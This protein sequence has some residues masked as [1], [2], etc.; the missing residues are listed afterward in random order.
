M[1]K[2]INKA[3][4]IGSGIMG[5]GIAALCAGAGIP[6]L[7][8]DIVPFDLKDEEKN[9]RDARNKIVNAGF[10]A[11]KKSSPP[12]FLDK[13]RDWKL[14]ETGNLENDF[15]KLKECD[16]IF[17]VIVE[18][19]KLKQQLFS[20]IE[21]IR[22]EDA[23]V[24]SNTSGLPL[25][26]MSAGLG[27]EFRQH[28]MIMHFFNPVRY[29]KLVELVKST[30]TKKD[31]YDF[32][33]N[34]AEKILGKGVVW[35]K[36]TPNFVGNRIGVALIAQTFRLFETENI[37]VHDVDT[38]FG[39]FGFPKTGIFALCDL[40]G[41]DT[42]G[43]LVKNSHDLLIK[44]EFKDIYKFPAFAM[45]MIGSKMF[46]NKT[47]DTGGFYKTVFDPATKKKIKTMLDIKTLKH[48]EF[49]INSAPAFFAEVKK[50][51]SLAARQR[52]IIES[53]PFVANVMAFLFVYAFGRVPE[54]SDTLKGIDD[55]M[56]WGYAWET[57]PFE[58]WD[59]Y[60]LKKSF[61]LIKDAGFKVPE[62]I[63]K[64]TE[65]GHKSF[66]IVKE[67]KKFYYDFKSGKYKE[68]V[69]SKDNII[70]SDLKAVRKNI[71]M[72][73]DSASLID[74]GDGVFNL[75]YHSKMNAINKQMIDFIRGAAAY[76]GDNGIG[77]VI[78][79]Q[80]SGNPGT[81]SAG[82]DLYYMITLAK[83][84][85]YSEIDDFLKDSH[86]TIISLKYSSFPVVAAPY[87]IAVGGGCE[88]CLAADRIVAHSE[89]YMGLVEI[90]AG[91]LPGGA[92]MIHLWERY[93]D[94]IPPETTIAD[95]GAYFAAAFTTVV[96]AKISSSAAEA[97]DMMYLRPA[98]RIVYNRDHLIGEA[99][100]E[101][102]RI[103][104]DGYRIPAKKKVY[105]MGQ[106]AQGMVLSRLRD[107]LLGGY[108]ASYG[109]YR[110]KSRVL[111]VGRRDNG[112]LC[113]RGLSA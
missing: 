108:C 26:A 63:K 6:T 32:V 43:H 22:S 73:S 77:L 89:L 106:A 104:E 10:D 55:A 41:L 16:V 53:S 101:V 69:K 90:G 107:M 31:V 88:T 94:S 52:M 60:G 62:K 58:I 72:T 5:G 19:L 20:K 68:I 64:M 45:E 25:K 67:D 93:M 95:Y 110:E 70:L 49:D 56:K 34:W 98:D 75:E 21:K 59:N 103:V 30:D 79:N 100:K 65:K 17:E 50:L 39:Q 105:V 112:T 2:R 24:L 78:G 23:I 51:G 96:M 76:V 1:L 14:I 81:F 38:L 61:K 3:G 18:N 46:G 9:N 40:I 99:K 80:T 28:F 57:G 74:I 11:L 82:G 12:A 54:I 85:K 7:L 86:N 27:K 66:Y 8:L 13:K 47:K 109:S 15:E 29:M 91:L 92:G 37:S 42:I 4:V 35:A 97:R 83:Q 113:Q 87:G 102:Q 36:D 71:V 33:A 48:K 111:Y 84:Q 44:D